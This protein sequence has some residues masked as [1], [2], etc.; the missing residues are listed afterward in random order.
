[1]TSLLLPPLYHIFCDEFGDQALKRSASEWFIVSAVVV[2]AKREPETTRWVSRINRQRRNHQG[3]VLHFTDLDERTKYWAT[4]F[5][6]KLPLRCFTVIS[7]KANMIGH[8]NVRAE[9]A[10]DLRIYGD[11]GTSFDNRPRRGLRYP[12]FVLKVLLERAT[13][14][15]HARSLR[16]YGEARPVAITIAQRGGFYLDPFRSYLEIDRMRAATRTGTLPG[17]LAWP[18]VNLDLITTAPANNVAGLQL[19][20]IVTGAFS[21]AVDERR[22]GS[23][24]RELTYNLAPRIAG[25]GSEKRAAKFGVTGLPWDLWKAG[26][27]TEQEQL[28][29]M[30]GYG[31]DK[32]VRPGPILPRGR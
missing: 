13:G 1:M 31:N 25:I 26:L 22:F 11:D 18:V 17:H 27:S 20:D 30:F 21:R 8:R 23:C 19:A 2:S 32:L 12:N 5:V 14:W 9:R 6:G 28:F 29:R 4:R 16:E 7:H 10:G 24:D 15:C 3:S